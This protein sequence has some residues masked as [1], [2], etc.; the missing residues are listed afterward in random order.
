MRMHPIRRLLIPA[1]AVTAMIVAFL[2]VPPWLSVFTPR[3]LVR[4]A[5]IAFLQTFLVVLGLAIPTSILGLLAS[6][7]AIVLSRAR[8]RRASIGVAGRWASCAE[9]CLWGWP[10][11]SS[12]RRS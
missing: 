9:A 10:S 3:W 12:A 5:K 2:A 4:G 7:S 1:L 8:G 11:W 6:T